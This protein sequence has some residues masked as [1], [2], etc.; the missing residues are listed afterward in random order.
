MTDVDGDNMGSNNSIP[1]GPHLWKFMLDNWV[2]QE[3]P[4]NVQNNPLLVVWLDQ[5]GFTNRTL[6]VLGPTTLDDYCWESC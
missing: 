6:L 5:Y 3:L 2:A 1:N 4:P